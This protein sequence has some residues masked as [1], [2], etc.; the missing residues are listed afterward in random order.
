MPTFAVAGCSY[1][2]RTR[3][4]KCYGDNMSELLPEYNYLHLAK[5]GGSNDRMWFVLTKAIM[6]DEL[7]EGDFIVLQYTDTMRKM[8]ACPTPN[9]SSTFGQDG[10]YL[11]GLCGQPE[12]WETQ[13]GTAYTTDFKMD[14]YVWQTEDSNKSL[15]ETIQ[16]TQ[17][18]IEYDMENWVTRHTQFEALCNQ[19]GI[20]L[21][22]LLNRYTETLP[23]GPQCDLKERMTAQCAHRS[24]SEKGVI[25]RGNTS[26][27]SI[28]DLGLKGGPDNGIYDPSHLSEEGHQLL[29]ELLVKHITG[30]KII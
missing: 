1:S 17:V 19:H 3:V 11:I 27:P 28:M 22:V 26:H 8:L 7:V 24:F 5:G 21:V 23:T 9:H 12:G 14:S 29:A 10:E 15:H 6:N 16:N 20:S 18:S 4:E 30:H 13:Y 2:D 25:K